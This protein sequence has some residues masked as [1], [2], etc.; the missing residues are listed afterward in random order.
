MSA[1][2]VQQIRDEVG[3]YACEFR[4]FDGNGEA[5]LIGIARLFIENMGS[6]HRF[7]GR[8]LNAHAPSLDTY[9]RSI[10][11][12]SRCAPAS[13]RAA[14]PSC[15]RNRSSAWSG[16]ARITRTASPMGRA[17]G[18]CAREAE[19]QVSQPG[20]AKRPPCRLRLTFRPSR[21]RSSHNS[22]SRRRS[23]PRRPSWKVGELPRAHVRRP[24]DGPWAPRFLSAIAC[25]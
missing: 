17:A 15:R 21:G 11:S 19:R 3:D 6:L 14:H 16:S 5:R 24:G 12:S 25:L 18:R 9:L 4:G 7:K 20:R 2:Q 8:D 22:C 23:C 10:V 1:E 13:A